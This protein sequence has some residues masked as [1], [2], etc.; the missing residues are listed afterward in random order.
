MNS[1][2]FLFLPGRGD[3]STDLNSV[4]LSWVYESENS[5]LKLAQGLLGDAAIASAQH[6]IT[7]VLP[8]ED[9]L[10]LKTEIPGKNIQHVRQAVP[11]A[12]ED[13]VVDDVDEL[14]FAISKST[15][16]QAD[17]QYNVA[18]IN[19]HY[20]E[21]V[22]QQL[23][24]ADI[25][26]DAMVADYFL[27]AE[28][29]TLFSVGK[30]ILFNG[31]NIKFTSSTETV[32]AAEIN[33][34]DDLAENETIKLIYCDKETDENSKLDKLTKNVNLDKEFCAVQPL[35]YLVKNSSKDNAVNFLQGLYK[36]KKNWSK[37][38]KTWFPVAVLFLIWLSVQSGLFIVDYFSLSKQNKILNAEIT[39]IYKRTFPK[40]QRIF[41]A[42][43]QM[44]S[45]LADLRKRKGQSGR[46]FTEMLS[47]SAN[48]FSRT[49]GLKIK[50]LRYYDGRINIELQIASLQALDKLKG[51]LNKEKGYKVEIQNASS[52][53]ETVTARIQIT[54]VEL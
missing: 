3:E 10:F 2:F 32:I 50:S 26:A 52:G 39:K 5:E 28:K 40:S 41:D 37:T 29:N 4:E 14:Y 8:G 20:L 16:A 36:K 7:V 45:E 25:Y 49:K 6:N 11:Y 38:T 22:I 30:R 1:S 12:L 42:A 48:I 23:E 43:A 33:L 15:D 53:K 46:S 19:K 18:V 34:A 24:N 47:G 35:L 13:S 44:K 21:S 54:G 17:N 27:L 9:V 51:Q 31:E